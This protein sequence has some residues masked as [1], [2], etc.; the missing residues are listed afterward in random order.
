[1]K[2]F[3]KLFLSCA[4]VSAMAVTASSAAF[5]APEDK[6]IS[7]T[8]G[9][10]GTVTVDDE[11]KTATIKDLAVA[12]TVDADTEVTFLVIKGAV[13]TEVADTDVMG[14]DQNTNEAA[15]TD[16]KPANAGLK[17]GENN[18]ATPTTGTQ[19]YTVMVGYTSGGEFKKATGTFTLGTALGEDII[20]GDTNLSGGEEPITGADSVFILR[21]LAG[22]SGT[23]IASV[24]TTVNATPAE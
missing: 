13:G 15:S 2:K 1:M 23:D 14:I 16:V 22:Q 21:Y 9:L 10:T 19:L 17:A 5:A 6:T 24:G 8:D 7:S 12:D 4:L 20:I 3:T 18:V 11:A